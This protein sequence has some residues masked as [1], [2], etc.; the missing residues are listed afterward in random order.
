VAILLH[1]LDTTEGIEHTEEKRLLFS[2]NSVNSVV[3]GPA[4]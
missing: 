2:V 4:G 3:P 1:Q